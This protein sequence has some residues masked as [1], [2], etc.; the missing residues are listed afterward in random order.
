MGIYS[1][2]NYEKYKTKTIRLNSQ[3]KMPPNFGMDQIH[4]IKLP[5]ASLEPSRGKFNLE[6]IHK[7]MDNVENKVLVLE[8]DIPVWVEKQE[9]DYF[10]AFIR[11]VGS[12][13]GKDKKLVGVIISTINNSK[14]EWDAYIDSFDKTTIFANLENN[15]LIDYLKSNNRDFGLLVKCSENN[16]IDCC[17]RFAKQ[18]L[19]HLW[20]KSPVLIHVTDDICGPNI[21][22]EIYRWHGG[23]SN[24]PLDLGYNLTLRR[25]TYPE[26]V[27]SKGALPCRFWFENIG[28]TRIYQPFLIKLQIKPHGLQLLNKRSS[29]YELTLQCSTESWLIG[30]ITHNEIIQLPNIETG[31]YS[32]S[33][34]LFLLDHTPIHLNNE[35]TARN[36][37]CEVGTICIDNKE[38]NELFR[39]W[40][41]YY[42]EG[43]YP[44]EDP[45][46]PEDEE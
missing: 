1:L 40:D 38:R 46:T 36:G 31:M 45:Q 25:V 12:F 2:E 37:F 13:I 35:N 26:T 17:E 11:R 30:D 32:L 10:A 15:R 3:S 5:W 41:T 19:Q 29:Y 16:W 27:S 34:G 44:L 9:S 42:P 23:L 7:E 6:V 24:K 8:P 18:N 43:Y 39:I 28:T 14:A 21:R 22:R 20:K 33:I 4:Y